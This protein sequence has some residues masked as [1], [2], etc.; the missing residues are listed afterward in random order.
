MS[1]MVDHSNYN[2][3][4]GPCFK[5]EMIPLAQQMLSL[6]LPSFVFQNFGY[7][8][9]G[10]CAASLSYPSTD[11]V[12]YRQVSDLEAFQ[13]FTS[14]HMTILKAVRLTLLASGG[15]KS[16]NQKMVPRSH[17]DFQRKLPASL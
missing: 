4:P 11:Y 1:A 6:A 16:K 15:I 5:F 14:P 12:C 17:L 9:A 7:V 2:T 13:L 8:Q 3:N 10:P